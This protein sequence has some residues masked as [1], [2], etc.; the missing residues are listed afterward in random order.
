MPL[1]F[2]HISIQ[3]EIDAIF[4][5]FQGL[6]ESISQSISQLV[7]KMLQL[8]AIEICKHSLKGVDIF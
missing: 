8:K 6:V 5:L 3:I 1:V 7:R 4:F 2:L